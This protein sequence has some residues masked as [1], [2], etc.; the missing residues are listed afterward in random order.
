MDFTLKMA[1]GMIVTKI[2]IKISKELNFRKNENENAFS[3]LQWQHIRAH[4]HIKQIL[5]SFSFWR[6]MNGFFFKH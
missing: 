4:M 1:V 3:L 5:S 2:I 6:I